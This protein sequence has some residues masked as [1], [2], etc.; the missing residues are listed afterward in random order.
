MKKEN[1][2]ALA[3]IIVNMVKNGNEEY[4]LDT[5]MESFEVFLP[6]DMPHGAVYEA[7]RYD[8]DNTSVIHL[9]IKEQNTATLGEKS[10]D[11]ILPKRKLG[12][13]YGK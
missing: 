6:E 12:K 8:T 7:N 3:K 2:E 5:L 11:I 13:D 9:W 10:F 4:V 1:I